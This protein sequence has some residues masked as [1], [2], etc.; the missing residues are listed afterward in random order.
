MRIAIDKNSLE[1]Y[2]DKNEFIYIY[3]EEKL[4]DLI[5]LGLHCV[6]YKNV[7][8]VDVNLTKYKINCLKEAEPT[9][10]D[11]DQL[12][13]KR[14]YKYAIIVPNFNNDRG[15]YEGKTYFC[16]CIESI[17]NQTYKNFELII[18]DDCSTDTSVNTAKAYQ[19]KDKR[20]HLIENIR[21][22]YNGGSRNVGIEYA[23]KN[24]EFDYFVFLDSDDWW[25][26]NKVL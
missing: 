12:P 11:Y 20:I 18:V 5:K 26:H 24:L 17:L 22:R 16:N 25:K 10:K 1:A 13:P 2:N 14:D 23:L 19:E 21:K 3:S 9:D 15:N 8:Y 7:D 6:Y 4:E